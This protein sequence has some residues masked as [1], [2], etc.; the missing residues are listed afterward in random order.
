MP[1]L[2]S[3]PTF[4]RVLHKRGTIRRADDE[5]NR[6]CRQFGFF[7]ELAGGGKQF[8][9]VDELEKGDDVFVLIE[10]DDDYCATAYWYMGA[11]TNSLPPLASLA[12]RLADLP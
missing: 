11:R 8:F 1:L 7:I 2:G 6:R 4:F 12:E 10:R 9:D 3:S 5:S